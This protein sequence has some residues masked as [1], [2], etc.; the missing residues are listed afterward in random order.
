MGIYH[1]RDLVR[2]PGLL[3]LVRIPL[4]VVFAIVVREAVWAVV[5]L[6]LAAIS[7][8]L[9]GWYARH[10]HQQTPTGAVLDGITDK[11]FVL[12]VAIAL[13]A[14]GLLR[15]FELLLLGVRD[16]GEG[17]LALRLTVAGRS[18]T[19]LQLP[20]AANVLGKVA[21]CLQYASVVAVLLTWPY[22]FLWI[23]AAAASGS[24]AAASYWMREGRS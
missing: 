23:G 4:V 6:G 10:F 18:Q 11:V 22:R 14:S 7:D 24:V 2:V 1:V 13:L 12:G 17:L 21:T 5:V 8:V 16:I 19:E 3:S 15:P 20:H 9:D